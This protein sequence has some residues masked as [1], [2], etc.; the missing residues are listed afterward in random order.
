MADLSAEGEIVGGL[1]DRIAALEASAATTL[2]ALRAQ[3]QTASRIEAEVRLDTARRLDEVTPRITALEAS[4][5]ATGTQMAEFEADVVR[6]RQD[7]AAEIALAELRT[8]DRLD[9]VE[10]EIA[11]NA[12]GLEAVSWEVGRERLDFE[13][14]EDYRM[15][16]A[17]GV[18]LNISDADVAY[19]KVNGWIHLRDEGRFLRIDNHPI[20]QSL[21]FYDPSD[22]RSY[23]LVFTRVRPD[24]AIGY[25]RVPSEEGL[26]IVNQVTDPAFEG[27]L[28]EVR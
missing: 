7:V 9:S 3:V 2:E 13:L 6:M 22:D 4:S 11:G 17:P 14:F 18:V 20:Q 12:R 27:R 10:G 23:E 15:E 25:V 24:I 19:Q 26:R 8:S 5:A 28:S 1:A 21:A 16:V